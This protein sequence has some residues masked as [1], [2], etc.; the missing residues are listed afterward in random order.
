MSNPPPYD[1]GTPTNPDRR[2]LPPGW[3]EQYDKNYKAWFY[4]NTNENPPKSIWVHPSGPPP[5]AGPPQGFAPPPGPPPPGGGGYPPQGWGGPGWQGGSPPPGAW[6]PQGGWQGGPP[7]GWGGSPGWQGPPGG[8]GG[9]SMG[10]P[11]YYGQPQQPQYIVQ[12]KP[13]KEKKSKS[14]G[15]GVGTAVAAGGAGL[16]GGVLLGE[17]LENHDD[18]ERDMGYQDGFQD[19]ADF[20]G[21]GGDW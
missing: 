3:I 18:Y 11:G 13:A 12:G 8:Y 15:I 5:P 17:A 20:D 10:G 19:G 14:G 9:P 16:L 2:P 1:T 4:V 21:G 6:G 7:G